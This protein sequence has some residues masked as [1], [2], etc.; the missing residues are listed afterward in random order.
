MFIMNGPGFSARQFIIWAFG[1]IVAFS[2]IVTVA[3]LLTAVNWGAADQ[4][5]REALPPPQGLTTEE[6]GAKSP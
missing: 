2:A 4:E 6:T 5:V 3:A 1:G